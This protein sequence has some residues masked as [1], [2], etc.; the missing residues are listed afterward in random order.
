MRNYHF[1]ALIACILVRL[2]FNGITSDFL[3]QFYGTSLLEVF[4]ACTMV[5][6]FHKIF[7]SLYLERDCLYFGIY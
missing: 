1:S 7:F 2:C 3:A 5:L 4:S 6:T